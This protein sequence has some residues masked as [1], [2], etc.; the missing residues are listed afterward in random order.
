MVDLPIEMLPVNMVLYKWSDQVNDS[1]KLPDWN[2]SITWICWYMTWIS[3]IVSSIL[4]LTCLLAK[5]AMKRH[6]YQLPILRLSRPQWAPRP[7]LLAVR[8]KLVF[9]GGH[10]WPP[11]I[12]RGSTLMLPCQTCAK[13]TKMNWLLTDW[14]VTDWLVTDWL[15]TDW[16]PTGC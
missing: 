2:M 15:N 9:P 6:H 12:V 13:L 11:A 7:L 8:Q 1:T 14:L 3:R 5:L 10:W 16:W 4:I